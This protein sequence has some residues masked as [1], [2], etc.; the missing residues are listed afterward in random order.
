MSSPL[1]GGNILPS[2]NKVDNIKKISAW[3][4][5]NSALVP[6][7]LKYKVR[8]KDSHHGRWGLEIMIKGIE[9]TLAND[10]DDEIELNM[11]E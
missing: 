8:L 7:T 3:P 4:V 6:G 1:E 11:A 10:R 5:E 9:K 2:T